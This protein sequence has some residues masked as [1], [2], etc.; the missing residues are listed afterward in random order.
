MIVTSNQDLL[1]SWLCKKINLMP[2]ENI[3]CIGQIDETRIVGVIGFDGY[4]GASCMMHVAG[5]GNW[6]TRS[7]M[8]AAFDYPFN[9]M[10]CNVVFG[11]IPS[12][13]KVSVHFTKRV[14]FKVLDEIRDAHPD[15]SLLLM[16]MRPE[17]CRWLGERYGRD[18][19]APRMMSYG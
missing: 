6:C 17:E 8:W 10:K 15:G 12:S 2:T 9:V 11:L 1:A 13:N 3:R 16:A 19:A 18:I 5:E 4:N 14:G 7:L